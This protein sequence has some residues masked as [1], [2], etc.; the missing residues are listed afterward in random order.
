M[1]AALLAL[2]GCGSRDGKL[3]AAQKKEYEETSKAMQNAPGMMSQGAQGPQ[4]KGGNPQNPYGA[5]Y[6]TGS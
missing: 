6:P 2:T 4:T 5:G 3:G 1:C